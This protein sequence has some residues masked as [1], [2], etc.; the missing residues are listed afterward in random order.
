[1]SAGRTV[2]LGAT[3][4][5]I[6]GVA[7]GGRSVCVGGS[8]SVGNGVAVPSSIMAGVSVAVLDTSCSTVGVCTG[9]SGVGVRECMAE[10]C[11]VGA[12]A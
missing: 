5:S 1:M 8:V 3:V 2:G 6:V 7:V 11:L 10:L 9:T 12:K 4:G